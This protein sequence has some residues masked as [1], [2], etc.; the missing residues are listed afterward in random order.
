VGVCPD[1]LLHCAAGGASARGGPC[2]RGHCLDARCT[3]PRCCRCACCRRG[4]RTLLNVSP[5]VHEVGHQHMAAMHHCARQ[6]GAHSP[7]LM[8]A[9][10]R[11]LLTAG[12][13]L[14]GGCSGVQWALSALLDGARAAVNPTG[15]VECTEMLAAAVGWTR[16]AAGW[17]SSAE[18]CYDIRSLTRCLCHEL[19]LY[20]GSNHDP[21]PH[22]RT[23]Y[24]GGNAS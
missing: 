12:I 22:V 14:A 17:H 7:V 8:A 9:A 6:S 16:P 19:Q 5:W 11:D 24:L 4:L 1:Q 18:R 21:P 2:W 10:Q 20:A 3:S 23:T 13:C 15:K